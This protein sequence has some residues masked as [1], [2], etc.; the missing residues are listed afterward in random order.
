MKHTKSSALLSLLAGW[1]ALAPFDGNAQTASAGASKVS[2]NESAVQMSPF[3]VNTDKDVG[4]AAQETLSGTRLRMDL[5]DVGA[6]LSVLT[7][8]FLE[9]LGVHSSTQALLYTP[10]VDTYIGDNTGDFNGA[11]QLFGNGQRYPYAVLRLDQVRRT[12][13]SQPSS[14]TIP[15]M[16]NS[17]LSRVDRMPCSSV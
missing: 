15:I 9:D 3:E 1:F 6:S 11:Q 14:A 17:L 7:P 5:R 16:S 12:I 13:F 10:S 4:Y 2:T 8:E